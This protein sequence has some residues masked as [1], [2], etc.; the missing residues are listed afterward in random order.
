MVQ[1]GGR[2]AG[3]TV[4]SGAPKA[5][6]RV[7][8]DG[9]A[10]YSAGVPFFSTSRGPAARARDE[11]EV[12]SRPKASSV[13]VRTGDYFFVK[14]NISS[15]DKGKHAHR[16]P[17]SPLAASSS[18]AVGSPPTSSSFP[19]AI[20]ARRWVLR[21][22]SGADFVPDK[23]DEEAGLTPGNEDNAVRRKIC[24]EKPC[25]PLSTDGINK[26]ENE[27]WESM[28]SLSPAASSRR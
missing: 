21:S 24:P 17:K 5:I 14:N 23:A 7:G 22:F 12:V 25:F 4:R 19:A 13:H 18:L 3:N 26:G 27:K 10:R 2:S 28:K 11:H 20:F 15:V 16:R 9:R 8:C 6:G 1:G